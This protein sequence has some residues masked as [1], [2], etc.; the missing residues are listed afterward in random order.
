[1]EEKQNTAASV[2]ELRR[3]S[4]R[5]YGRQWDQLKRILKKGVQWYVDKVDLPQKI[6]IT[7]PLGKGLKTG[8]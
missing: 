5:R 2:I 4:C 7:A 8:W 1:M 6:R 3:E